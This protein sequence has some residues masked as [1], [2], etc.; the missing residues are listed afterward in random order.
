MDK[1]LVYLISALVVV[2]SCLIGL[3]FWPSEEIIVVPEPEPT[4]FDFGVQVPN[5]T[6]YHFSD[7]GDVM[8]AS[9]DNWSVFTG[10]GMGALLSAP[11][12]TDWVEIQRVRAVSSHFPGTG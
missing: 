1:R 7:Y 11:L 9:A 5:T 12:Q 4:P 2:S 6:F 10:I 8:N 3:K